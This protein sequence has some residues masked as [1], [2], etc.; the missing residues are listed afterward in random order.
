MASSTGHEIDDD[1]MAANDDDTDDEAL[2]DR[3]HGVT[4]TTSGD[5]TATDDYEWT[6]TE[7]E[8]EVR[9]RGPSIATQLSK[10]RSVDIV[11]S[12]EGQAA[13][14]DPS[15]DTVLPSD[16][17]HRIIENGLSSSLSARNFSMM[18]NDSISASS[19]VRLLP[20]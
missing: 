10:Y 6:A 5:V 15:P 19:F 14:C 16:G 3:H 18:R 1:T 2:S 9:R 8:P 11:Q 4:G 12:R 20:R 7:S 13:K 17:D